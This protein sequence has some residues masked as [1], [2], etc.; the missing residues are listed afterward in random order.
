[1][2]IIVA[3]FDYLSYLIGQS[4]NSVK[5]SQKIRCLIVKHNKHKYIHVHGIQ[6]LKWSIT[7]Y[8]VI[9]IWTCTSTGYMRS[10]NMFKVQVL[11]MFFL[12][13]TYTCSSNCLISIF[14]QYSL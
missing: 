13:G 6:V 2:E 9:S 3:L 10:T 7:I 1:M 4:F 11:K 14:I 12:K 5:I 8:N